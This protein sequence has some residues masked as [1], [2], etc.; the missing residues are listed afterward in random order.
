MDRLLGEHGIGADSAA[1]RREFERRMEDRRAEKTDEKAL[2]PLRRDWC[3]GSEPFQREMLERMEGRMG[4]HHSGELLRES[5][6]AK[7][8]RIIAEELRHLGWKES[9]LAVRRKSDPGKL[10]M[11]ARLRR[12]TTLPLK[13]IAARVQLGTSKSANAKLHLWMKANPEQAGRQK[14]APEEKD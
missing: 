10:A 9:D 8:E 4:P 1:S 3:L 2:Q 12:Q 7:A 11:A 5:A 6:E 13:W 14:P